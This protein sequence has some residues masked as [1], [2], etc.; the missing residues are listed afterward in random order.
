MALEQD[1]PLAPYARAVPA[2]GAALRRHEAGDLAGARAGYLEL[3]DQPELTGI[4]LHQLGILAANRG[5]HLRAAEM[6]RRALRLEPGH[7]MIGRNLAAALDRVGNP[8]A[9]VAVLV[10]LGC[11]LQLAGHYPPAIAFYQEVLARDPLNY[12]A[13][14]NLGTALAWQEQLP[15]AARHLVDALALYGRLF[16]G[17]AAFAR[18][19][20]TGLAGK[21]A[22]FPRGTALPAGPP[23]GA[24]EKIEDALTTLGKVMNE[25][26]L[27]EE[28][29]ACY[30]ESSRL[31]PGYALGHWNLSLALLTKGD[32]RR[33]WREYEWRWQ[34]RDFPE[35]RRLLPAPDWQGEDPAG[36]R[37]VVWGEQGFG[38]VIQLAPLVSRLK[39]KGA[40]IVFE[41]PTPLV[42]LMKQSLDG[43]EVIG[44]GND[45]H[46]LAVGTL[47]DFVLPQFSLPERLGLETADLPLAAA[48]LRSDPADDAAWAARIPASDK[49]KVGL[50]WGGRPNQADNPKRSI[51]LVLLKPLLEAEGISWYGL[52]LG[53]AQAEL[54]A[55]GLAG[56]TDLSPDLKDFADT[57][58]AIA[59]L[60]LVISVCTAVAHLA[61]AMG[62]PVWLL[63]RT[64][65]DWRWGREGDRSA[66]YPSMRIFRQKR[67]GDW[68]GVIAEVKEALA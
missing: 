37:I 40:D 53:P 7:I 21:L 44:R 43:V 23:G 38:D 30:E 19:L 20:E 50:V 63:A 28:A 3:V 26:G 4:C 49:K 29:L 45:P 8:A 18:E 25:S 10:D 64:P 66:W 12:A 47:P 67:M 42:R 15:A 61:G 59:Q 54:A 17:V 2:F 56:I 58:A 11:T 14:V 1:H 33:G 41:V 31:A 32:F 52:Q 5:D 34:W 6:F 46:T 9:A 68:Q 55:S 39:A 36:R 51:P 22:G 24:L 48:Y 13:N 62:K 16:P 60:D 27:S 35:A 65:A 57:A